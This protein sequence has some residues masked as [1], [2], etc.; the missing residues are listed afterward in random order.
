MKY[1]LALLS[2]LILSGHCNALVI[3]YSGVI[4]NPYGSITSN[5]IYANV[6]AGDII[7]GSF[8]YDSSEVTDIN[9][10]DA[11]GQYLFSAANSSFTFSIL[12]T[13]NSNIE[14]HSYSGYI[15]LITTQNDWQYSPNPSLFPTTDAYGVTGRFNHGA[16]VGIGLQNRNI[17]LDL[18][19]TDQLPSSPLELNNYTYSFGYINLDDVPGQ[20][21]FMPTALYVSNSVSVSEPTSLSILLLC[22]ALLAFRHLHRLGTAKY[23]MHCLLPP[24]VIEKQGA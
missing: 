9:S 7:K 2:S 15:S 21:D 16:E 4:T 18:V 23:R 8:S 5:S 17:N 14:L 1:I 24:A 20:I 12:D 10:W 13:S 3:E 11:V 19:N 22:L 6:E